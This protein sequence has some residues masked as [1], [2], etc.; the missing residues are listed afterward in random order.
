MKRIHLEKSRLMIG[1]LLLAFAAVMFLFSDVTTTGIA[2]IGTL[3]VIAIV[4]SIRR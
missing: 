3:G 1:L 4:L 2:V